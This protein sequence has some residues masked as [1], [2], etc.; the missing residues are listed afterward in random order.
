[1]SIGKV[2]L[3]V[4]ILLILVA[5]S[6][7]MQMQSGWYRGIVQI[8]GKLDDWDGLW[9]FPENG[10]LALAAKNDG[11][12]LYLAVK[13]RDKRVI[14]NIASSGFEVL[15][16]RKGG[17]TGRYRLQYSSTISPSL[18][19]K[20]S[21]SADFHEN[22]INKALTQALV[23]PLKL[24]SVNWQGNMQEFTG[25]GSSYSSYQDDEWFCEFKVPMSGLKTIPAPGSKIG[26]GFAAYPPAGNQTSYSASQ[27][28]ST[29]NIKTEWWVKLTLA[30]PPE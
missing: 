7:P 4:L 3:H 28:A 2:M 5:C 1:M 26:I 17:Q 30:T 19:N 20:M 29:E 13:T 11:Q 18:Y 24:R 14:R 10:R 8:D 21:L 22:M 6:A 27:S 15:I 25:R 23:G 16:D 12:D 9:R